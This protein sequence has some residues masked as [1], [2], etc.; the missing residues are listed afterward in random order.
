MANK[1]KYMGVTSTQELINLL[2]ADL[3]QKQDIIQFTKL[4]AP[5]LAVGRTYQ[6]TG[7]TTAQFTQG[8]IYHSDGFNWMPVYEALENKTWTVVTTLPSFDDADYNTIYFVMQGDQMVG[9]LKGTDQ[10]EQITSN[11][12]WQLVTSLP[13]WASADATVLY[14]LLDSTT[15]M[16]TAAVKNPN[17][18][19][20]WYELGGGKAN[21]NE[22]TNTPIINGI[23]LQNTVEPEEAKE[24]ELEASVK[25]YPDAPHYDPDA[26][27]P[28]TAT[29]F[30][31]NEAELE[32]FTD[33]DIKQ[34]WEEV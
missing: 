7:P 5:E 18:E 22:L 9:Y 34:L 4:P 31:V 21:F 32:G 29:K 1:I 16:L 27:Y 30:R 3:A 14:M 28:T 20:A 11:T 25:K 2:K 15:N 13:P 33:E 8:H 10:M 12:S 23:P 19:D 24:I 26:V 17:E 6:Y